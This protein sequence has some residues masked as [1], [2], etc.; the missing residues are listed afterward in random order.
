[1][2]DFQLFPQIKF[3]PKWCKYNSID[4]KYEGIPQALQ[5]KFLMSYKYLS[6]FLLLFALESLNCGALA[7]NKRKTPIIL[8][9]AHIIATVCKHFW[10]YVNLQIFVS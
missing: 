2:K 1:M 6:V 5:T 10:F 3:T 4:T 7:N 9:K 8:L